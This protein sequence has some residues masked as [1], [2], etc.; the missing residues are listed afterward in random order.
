MGELSWLPFRIP[1]LID[2]LDILVISFIIYKLLVLIRG[3]RAVQML[4]GIIFLMVISYVSGV[5]GLITLK[6]T[7]DYTISFLPIA[8]IVLFQNEIRKILARLGSNPILQFNAP[9]LGETRI[10][11]IIKAAQILSRE[12]KGA[13]IVL[14]QEQGLGHHIETGIRMDATIS[15]DL[16]VNIFEPKTPLHDG[17]VI[18][19]EDRITAAGCLL[20]LSS[21]ANLPPHFGTRHRAGIG[22][23]EETDSV[24]VIVSEETGKI[25]F[26]RNG[27]IMHYKDQTAEG[28]KKHLIGLLHMDL[29]SGSQSR[30]AVFMSSIRERLRGNHDES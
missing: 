17:A 22:I 25:S 8:I 18:I 13:L 29:K 3:T 5:L 14:Q 28:M 16:L 23:T 21:S 4:I 12:R 24:S 30:V 10:D 7:V 15:Y 1:G 6:T 2:I 11:Q 19:I 20:P 9:S 26:A 27:M